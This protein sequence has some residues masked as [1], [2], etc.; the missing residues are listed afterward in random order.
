MDA[1]VA[2]LPSAT[3]R[4]LGRL[5]PREAAESVAA[6][7]ARETASGSTLFAETVAPL[8]DPAGPAS[9]SARRAAAFKAKARDA[10]A[11]N[12][13]KE[14]LDHLTTAL[15]FL[16]A[17]EEN[18]IH[19]TTRVSELESP[20]TAG[21]LR[22]DRA[23]VLLRLASRE[24]DTREKKN[25]CDDSA[26][27]ISDGERYFAS[28]YARLALRDAA[29]AAGAD[30]SCHKS[31]LRLG[32]AARALGRLEVAKSAFRDALGLM[33]VTDPARRS[34]ERRLA[35]AEGRT[36]LTRL[37]RSDDA[38]GIK[39]GIKKNDD[40]APDDAPVSRRTV[41]NAKPKETR[42]VEVRLVSN[43]SNDTSHCGLGVFST[44]PRMDPG[45]VFGSADG[46]FASASVPAK[47][48]RS[49]RC[50]F[51][52][53]ALSVAPTPCRACSV[54]SY[55]DEACRDEDVAH[56]KFECGTET[57]GCW[58]SVLPSETRLAMRCLAANAGGGDENAPIRALHMRWADFDADA[59]ARLAATAVVAS[60][61]ATRRR[62]HLAAALSPGAVMEATCAVLG[63]AFAV[64]SP[65]FSRGGTSSFGP[66]PR[67]AEVSR[68]ANLRAALVDKGRSLGAYLDAWFVLSEEAETV[69]LATFP[70]TSRLNH[71]C[72]PN[73][74]VELVLS[75]PGKKQ[76]R[77]TIRPH[78][79]SS[80]PVVRATTRATRPCGKHEE[81][82][83]SY[84][85]VIGSAPRRARRE[86]LRAS[87]GFV[88]ACEGCLRDV[89]EDEPARIPQTKFGADVAAVDDDDAAR[90]GVVMDDARASFS[91]SCDTESARSAHLKR[92]ETAIGE[93]RELRT[94]ARGD[95][96]MADG[97]MEDAR[98]FRERKLLAEALDA[99]ALG[100]VTLSRTRA[101]PKRG[102]AF[103]EH[104]ASSAREALHVLVNSLGYPEQDSLTVALERARVAALDAACSR[105][106]ASRADL[107][108]ARRVLRAALGDSHE[109]EHDDTRELGRVVDGGLER[110]ALFAVDALLASFSPN[111][112]S[113]N[114]GCRVG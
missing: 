23:A 56:A 54:S 41:R 33:A 24:H 52:H 57:S 44:S 71:S 104:A 14:A 90:W 34:V 1:I 55:C 102:L 88:C 77:T 78:E 109:N 94:N 100:L 12:R 106:E 101:C 108:R 27:L 4:D 17:P 30:A 79:Y 58:W 98:W 107:E 38:T 62:E 6:F 85:P 11:R 83:V 92:L 25:S 45:D 70:E 99:R 93:L 16:P 103:V 29:V 111:D 75:V 89:F 87:H 8:T 59:R 13:L 63:N 60:H 15:K 21:S 7:L 53:R 113:R 48:N 28:S 3:V 47:S 74:H 32:V 49:S 35:E 26:T 81:L 50:S 68:L 110:R 69:A 42:T 66:D 65:F 5:G 9:K 39:P 105:F 91:S 114:A 20:P 40:I 112:H 61:C 86:R 67:S 2:S 37:S 10:F 64:K 43:D 80:P 19:S 46:E 97:K 51:C 95:G 73:A 22:N 82:R 76:K 96:K 31:R 18:I 72:D 84:G 36:R